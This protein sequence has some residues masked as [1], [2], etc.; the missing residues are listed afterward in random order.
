MIPPDPYRLADFAAGRGD[1]V[2]VAVGALPPS[3]RPNDGDGI[4]IFRRAPACPVA[5]FTAR[6]NG[7]AVCRSSSFP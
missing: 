2:M 7:R 3:P 5:D 4:T 1:A 6:P